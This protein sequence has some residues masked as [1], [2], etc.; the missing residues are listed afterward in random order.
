VLGNSVHQLAN[1]VHPACQQ[2]TLISRK[3]NENNERAVLVRAAFSV[4]GCDV[5]PGEIELG[6][7]APASPQSC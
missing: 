5:I 4:S 7:A 6:T 3:S 2:R 1:S